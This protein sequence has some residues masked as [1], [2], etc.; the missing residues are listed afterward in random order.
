[1]SEYG[2]RS[3]FFSRKEAKAFVLLRRRI[4]RSRPWS[5]LR[6]EYGFPETKQKRLFCCAERFDNAGLGV[7]DI[8][9][10]G[11]LVMRIGLLYSSFRERS[12]RVSEEER[13]GKGDPGVGFAPKVNGKK[14]ERWF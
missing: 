3:F 11:S 2:C 14:G 1:V 12:K 6:P 13:F 8:F 7:F 5:L 4:R 10:P 9:G